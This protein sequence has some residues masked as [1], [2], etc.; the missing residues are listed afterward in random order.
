MKNTI[1]V[2]MLMMAVAT[3]AAAQAQLP[4]IMVRP[5]KS[6]CSQNG[7]TTVVDNQGQQVEICDYAKALNDPKMLQSITEIEALLKE[8]G[9][10]TTSMQTRTE[11][12]NDFAAEELLMDD[13]EGNYVDKSALDISRERAMADIYLDVNWTVDKIGP[14]SQL[15]YVLQGKDYYTGDD[16]CSVT[17]IGE[18]TISA[19]E[20]VLLREAVMGKMPELKDRLSTYFTSILERGRSV[21]VAIRVSTGSDVNLS[22]AAEG[23]NIG[24]VI[25]KWILTNAVE[26]RAE[27]E[28]SSATSANYTVNIPLY[29]TDQL[30][31]STEDFL[32]QL[33]GYLASQPYGIKS[34]V[35][36][37]GLGR[38]TLL[39]QGKQ[40]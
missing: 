9:L 20:A 2:M 35:S 12:I 38:A 1:I 19:T 25:Y 16:V 31:M 28:R 33:S 13:G 27:A 15:S 3:D 4:T 7:Y 30:P 39:I 6:W 10:K 14:K 32:W 40:Y 18:P 24:R 34:T 11:A 22:T 37:Q 26:H 5:G 36:N 23:G 29:D 17:G 8:E 21:Y